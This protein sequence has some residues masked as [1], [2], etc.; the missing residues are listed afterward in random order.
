MENRASDLLGKAIELRTSHE[1]SEEG[2]LARLME[3]PAG[4]AFT[5]AMVDEVFRSQHPSIQARRWRG[6]L[7]D[8][9]IPHYLNLFDRTLLGLGAAASAL[10]PQLVMPL[11]ARRLRQDSARVILAAEQPKLDHYLERRTDDGFRINLNQLGEAVLGED[12]AAHRLNV[13]LDHLAN[14]RVDYV[15]VKISAIFSQINLTAWQESLATIK[16]RLRQLYRAAFALRKFVNL[17]M[18]EYRDLSLTLAAFREL[19]DEPEFHD[20][21]AGVVLQ[22]YLPDSWS[23]QQELTEWAIRR[24]ATGGAEI[25]LRLVKGANLAM[26]TVEAEL[27]GWARALYANKLETD[28]NFRRMLE[29]GCQPGNAAAVRLGVASH[30]LFDVALALELR[31][32]LG[33]GKRVE[34]EMLEGMANHEARAIRQS[35]GSVLLYAPVVRDDDFPGAMAY[36]VRRLDENTAPQNFL[37]SAFALEP[38]SPAWTRELDRFR[39]GWEMRTTV[40]ARSNRA[41]SATEIERNEAFHNEPDSDWT[42]ADVREKLAAALAGR[43]AQPLPPLASLEDVLST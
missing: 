22:A 28:A 40:S 19:L 7:R 42:Q 10:A 41:H 13:I 38:G 14:P 27:H 11:V 21:S 43:R 9:G 6:L 26:E 24:V 35:A 36:L 12:E 25:K 15:S 2:K 31:E 32:R 37:R 16:S 29:F 17:D 8:F 30:N 23:A 1:K 5:L 18:E 33:T 3:D 4:K 39:R 20:L 34:I